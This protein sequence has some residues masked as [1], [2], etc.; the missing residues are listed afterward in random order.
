MSRALTHCSNKIYS[1][2]E[3]I[4]KHVIRFGM[5]LQSLGCTIILHTVQIKTVHTKFSRYSICFRFAAQNRV[6]WCIFWLLEVQ[7]D[8]WVVGVFFT[9]FVASHWELTVLFSSHYALWNRRKFPQEHLNNRVALHTQTTCQLLGW[10]GGSVAAGRWTW[11]RKVLQDFAISRELISQTF[12]VTL[13]KTTLSGAAWWLGPPSCT[14]LMSVLSSV[15][16]LKANNSVATGNFRGVFTFGRGF[17]GIYYLCNIVQPPCSTL[18]KL[19]S[20]F[21]WFYKNVW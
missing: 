1:L 21:R 3:T 11:R 8:S 17:W 2:N 18:L 16:P 20:L 14:R 15:Q 19:E 9:I 6:K 10:F 7:N 13:Q 4:C 12:G 5:I